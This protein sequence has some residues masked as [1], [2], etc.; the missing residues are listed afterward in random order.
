MVNSKYS[1]LKAS[2][3]DDSYSNSTAYVTFIRI[4]SELMKITAVTFPAV[5]E[6][7]LPGSHFTL[8]TLTVTRG[9]D[10]STPSEHEDKANVLAPSYNNWPGMSPEE[11]LR[12]WER[13]LRA[14][15][16]LEGKG[17]EL[18]ADKVHLTYEVD[19]VSTYASDMLSN[20]TIAA[21]NTGYS[22]SWYDCYTDS[23]LRPVDV[24]GKP[25]VK[26]PFWNTKTDA[27]YTREE[28]DTEQR[29]RLT[30]TWKS[31]RSTF[32]YYPTILANNVAT[33]YCQGG[34][35]AQRQ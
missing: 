24:G 28:F 14:D 35:Y 33:F 16:F 3:S 18:E 9:F 4:G 6:R 21:V 25:L 34:R 1:P 22:G 2:T 7:Q 32:D 11:A 17:A 27:L 30:R 20:S 23:E 8:Q 29:A 31:I 12:N 5:P 13:Q 26:F 10:G 19:P 15:L